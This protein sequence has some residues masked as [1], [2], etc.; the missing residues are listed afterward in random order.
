MKLSLIIFCIAF[1]IQVQAQNANQAYIDSLKDFRNH[2][3]ESHEI[4]K[5]DNKQF[6]QFFPIDPAYNVTCK[7][8]RIENDKWFSMSTSGKS[9]QIYRRYGKLTFS[10]HD[11]TLHLFVYQ[12]QS[13][14]TNKEYKDYLFIPF[15]DVT[16][17]IESYG[18][19]RYLEYYIG[20][21]KNNSLQ[22]DFNKAYNPYCAYTTGYNYPIPPKE[23]DL[24]VAILAG[25]KNYGKH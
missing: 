22:L 23:N 1:A 25:E 6:L 10:I 8:E 16:S 12:S 7:F 11:T 17:G 9:K 21:I 18:G 3:I 4:V 13:L 14:M 24:P 20:D 2:Y 19:G 5:K 15:T